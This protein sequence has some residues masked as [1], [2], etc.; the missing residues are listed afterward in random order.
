MSGLMAAVAVGAILAGGVQ[1]PVQDRRALCASV[2]DGTACDNI[3]RGLSD[4]RS[5]RQWKM[6]AGKAP[7]P[8][9]G[10]ACRQELGSGWHLPKL[11][12]LDDA[13][14]RTLFGYC[15]LTAWSAD[16][17]RGTTAWVVGARYEG[18]PRCV[19]VEG[20]GQLCIG[21]CGPLWQVRDVNEIG[22]AHDVVCVR[23]R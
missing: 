3:V 8:A 11:A 10:D 21:G 6:L 15:S 9:A 22:E 17:G 12:E 4:L 5:G 16:A 19:D 13:F 14:E 7:W 23:D 18:S 1:D 2:D 20:G